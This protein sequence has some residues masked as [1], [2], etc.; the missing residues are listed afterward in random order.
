MEDYEMTGENTDKDIGMLEAKIDLILSKQVEL[1]KRIFGNGRE[2][3]LERQ[4][5]LEQLMNQVF[6]A[7]KENLEISKCNSKD[8]STIKGDL[9]EHIQNPAIHLVEEKMKKFTEEGV[10]NVFTTKAWVK[11]IG[12]FVLISSIVHVVL[13]P[14]F[15]LPELWQVI[16]KQ[17]GL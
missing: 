12:I 4:T 16:L 8:I 15:G 1:D 14:E 9:N 7:Q 3:M 6:T 5:K 13:P 10:K 11:I 2:G 17:L